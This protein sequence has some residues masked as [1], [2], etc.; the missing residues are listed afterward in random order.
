M[1]PLGAHGISWIVKKNLSLSAYVRLFFSPIVPCFPTLR[2]W[3]SCHCAREGHIDGYFSEPSSSSPARVW[4]R[5]PVSCPSLW[6]MRRPCAST[7][8]WQPVYNHYASPLTPQDL[9]SEDEECPLNNVCVCVCVRGLIVLCAG[10]WNHI[11]VCQYLSQWQTS[12]QKISIKFTTLR[13]SSHTLCF[14]YATVA[15]NVAS[16]HGRIGSFVQSRFD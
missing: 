9:T 14:R 10:V 4:P 15:A 3:A 2:D 13:Y 16:T 11:Y 7:Y 12:C 8:C 5:D 6:W 1:S